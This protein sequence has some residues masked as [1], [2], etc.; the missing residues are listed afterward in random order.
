MIPEMGAGYLAEMTGILDEEL[1]SN[2]P[3]YLQHWI[4]I[5]KEDKNLLIEAASKA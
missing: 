4:S 1:V 2:H 3:A 5:L